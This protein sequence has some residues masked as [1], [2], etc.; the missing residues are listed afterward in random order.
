[1]WRICQLW[2]LSSY[3][4]WATPHAIQW[5]GAPP[6]PQ[7]SLPVCFFSESIH[8]LHWMHV[9]QVVTS[10]DAPITDKVKPALIVSIAHSRWWN[11]SAMWDSSQ[12]VRVHFVCH[13]YPRH[14]SISL[15]DTAHYPCLNFYRSGPHGNLSGDPV[16]HG[17][18]LENTPLWGS[19]P[20]LWVLQDSRRSGQKNVHICSAASSLIYL[21][22]LSWVISSL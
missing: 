3:V 14:L 18:P 1:M 8:I 19:R 2:L 9:F 22:D 20:S 5:W 4:L 12:R 16:C 7:H 10:A 15:Y 13:L 17:F 11:T 6:S 21:L